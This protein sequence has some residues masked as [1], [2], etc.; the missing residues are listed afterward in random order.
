MLARVRPL[1]KHLPDLILILAIISLPIAFVLHFYSR[2]RFIY[3]YDIGGFENVV[4]NLAQLFP[5]HL[6]QLLVQ[7][8][9]SLP[10]DY[11]YYYTLPLIPLVSLLGPNRAHYLVSV[12]A[13]YQVPFL[14]LMGFMFLQLAKTRSRLFFWLAV[15]VT[16]F[17]PSAWSPSL[18]GYPD[19]GGT[20]FMCLALGIY[21]HGAPQQR[22]WHYLLTGFCLAWAAIFRRYNLYGD[23]A[24]FLAAGLL[25]VIDL[26][27]LKNWRD[28]IQQGLRLASAGAA[29]LA[30][31]MIFNKPFL[32]NILTT[33]YYTLYSAYLRETQNMAFFFLDQYG[34][35]VWLVALV[36]Y[37]AAFRYNLAHRKQFLFVF[38]WGTALLL[39]WIFYVRQYGN[40][41]TLSVTIFISI[42]IA[43]L[44]EYL[45]TRSA[46][47]PQVLGV[48]ALALFMGINFFYAFDYLRF[49]TIEKAIRPVLS[50]RNPPF[51]RDD[52][53]Q[54]M[55]LVDYMR[56]ITPNREAIYVA[57]ASKT[58]NYDILMKGEY[59]RYL[60][61]AR[62]NMLVP[63]MIDSRDFYPLEPLLLADYVIVSAPLQQ[64][65]GEDKQLVVKYVYDTFQNGWAYSK[66]FEE[67][68]DQF[69]LGDGSITTRIYRRIRQT[70]F[71]TAMGMLKQL[72]TYIPQRPGGQKDWILLSKLYT[73]PTA[74]VQGLQYRYLLPPGAVEGEQ[75][76]QFLHVGAAA[77]QGSLLVTVPDLPEKMP[78]IQIEL[79]A[80]NHRDQQVTTLAQAS[81]TGGASFEVS[82]PYV[83]APS[84]N[85]QELSLLLQIRR[86]PGETFPLPG[87]VNLF[88]GLEP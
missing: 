29:L 46:R 7:F 31:L 22:W 4:N 76:V 10:T 15:L 82:L 43:G 72:E 57:D 52:Y 32:V 64:H 75:A 40:H 39:L 71:D 66:D 28:F 6:K 87:N 41:Y 20:V 61:E 80:Y 38:L 88:F 13:I 21:L 25:L 54:V 68:P 23:V 55:A 27:R 35:A 60:S 37:G 44:F 36:G 62:L 16:A 8:R 84:Q 49:P 5:A 47:V 42:G 34:W 9:D 51:V 73:P 50:L 19:I 78:N 30:T 11:N 14:L 63:A 12:V 83:L 26:I 81:W 77:R 56:A 45:L 2:E 85:M 79:L 74:L 67:L 17:L 24:F 58:F 48:G 53:E 70:D 65:L 86:Q 1:L 59:Q 33:N 18:R 69:H 3:F